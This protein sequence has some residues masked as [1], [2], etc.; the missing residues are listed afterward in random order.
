MDGIDGMEGNKMRQSATD[1]MLL[2][3]MSDQCTFN[4]GMSGRRT[5]QKTSSISSR[6]VNALAKTS[7]N[8]FI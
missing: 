3:Q 4:L 5:K 2:Q 7:N 6:K 1:L 8:L